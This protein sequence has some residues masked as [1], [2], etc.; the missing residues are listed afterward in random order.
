MLKK[1][2]VLPLII[3]T[4]LAVV[5]YKVK[6]KPAIEH[7]QAYFPTKSVKVITLKE[8]PFRNRATAYGNVEPATLLK[9][10]T[11]VSGKISYI[12]PEL[13]K[14][15]SLAKGTVVLRIEATTFEFSIEQSKE[16]LLS[17]QSSLTQLEVEE[18]S[19]KRSLIIA[20]ENLK[21]GEQELERLTSIWKQKLT[22]RSSIDTEEQK[23]L[24]LRQ[25]VEE[26]QGKVA[27]YI[28]R[29]SGIKA[30]IQ[31]AKTQLEQ[32]RDTLART[33]ITLPF[34]ARIGTVSVEKNEYLTAGAV[35]FE[36][37]GTEAIEINAQLPINQFYQL[38]SGIKKTALDLQDTK[39][40]QTALSKIK[41][42]A[43]V[44]LVGNE[45]SGNWQGKLRYIGES[46]DPDRDTVSLIVAVDNPYKKIIPSKRPPLLRGM[47]ASVE[48]FTPTRKVLVIPRHAIHQGRVYIANKDNKLEII[49]ITITHTQGD[50]VVVAE[51]I[52]G[53]VKENDRIIIS[54]V[55]PV[56]DGLP[57][58]PI[59]ADEYQQ[60]LAK[61]ALLGNR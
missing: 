43:L 49:P 56:I 41:L 4:A 28:S 60:Q 15:A 59:L 11:E 9:A 37:L 22:S 34:D 38:M 32:N 27:G 53:S 40:Y 31:Q 1:S 23:V 48:F 17:S 61:K 55:I 5:I 19:T 12:H 57:L 36:A 25:Q 21:I 45:G 7:K 39:K 42:Q 47:F 16:G 13:K 50:L 46:I 20:Q 35:L 8:L 24:Q 52:V 10:K 54:D 26:L 18:D 3:T 30:Q 33:E 51:E 14:G 2:I 6:N 58:K 44:N 29:K